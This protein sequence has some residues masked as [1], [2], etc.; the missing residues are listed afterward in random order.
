IAPID[1]R[2]TLRGSYFNHKLKPEVMF[3]HVVQQERISSE[4]GETITP[5]FTLI[6]LN[7]GY[8]FTKMIRLKAGVNNLLNQNY[9]E[10]LNRSV[11]GTM[12]TPI[13]APGRSMFAS[14]NLTF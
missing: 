7:V 5:S 14:F 3:R 2:Y 8:Q 11:R 1:I 6:D 4:F 9:Y 13:Y 12:A 10:H